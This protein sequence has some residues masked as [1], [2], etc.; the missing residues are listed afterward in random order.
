[1]M[2][3]GG[4][5]GGSGLRYV[6]CLSPSIHWKVG[7]SHMI[8]SCRQTLS[9]LNSKTL[10]FTPIGLFRCDDVDQIPAGRS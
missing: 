3:S 9:Y 4:N 2:V 6:Q 1:M 7:Y 10:T 8:L 5:V